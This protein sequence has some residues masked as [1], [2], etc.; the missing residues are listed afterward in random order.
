MISVSYE[1]HRPLLRARAIPSFM[2]LTAVSFLLASSLWA[3]TIPA[4]TELQVRLSNAVTSDKPSGQQVQAVLIAPVLQN[5]SPA[6]PEGL[7]LQCKTADAQAFKASADGSPES[8]AT[9]RIQL[10]QILEASGQAHPVAC[11]LSAVDNARETVDASGL[12]HGIEQSQTY[13]AQIEKGIGKLEAKHG[14]LADLLSGVKGSL[15][16]AVDPS[17]TYK[18]GVELT[19]KLTGPIEWTA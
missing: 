13:G 1:V 11:V 18:A 12:I 6:L 8:S 15:I 19:Y 3:I 7:R 16:K 5:G 4:G 9:L 17:I 14:A 10:T 2:K